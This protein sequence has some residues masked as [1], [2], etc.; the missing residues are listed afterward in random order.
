M[1]SFAI[2]H[3]TS[4]LPVREGLRRCHVGWH[5]CAYDGY[6]HPGLWPD[7]DGKPHMV[8]EAGGTLKLEP[9]HILELMDGGWDGN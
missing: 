6:A 2:V 4:K 5:A 3:F 7:A 8:I 9:I 1:S